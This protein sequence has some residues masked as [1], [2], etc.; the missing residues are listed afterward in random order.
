MSS[1]PPLSNAVGTVKF[2]CHNSLPGSFVL[3][4]PS[5]SFAVPIT[6]AWVI[7][8]SHG[9]PIFTVKFPTELMLVFADTFMLTFSPVEYW[10]FHPQSSGHMSNATTSNPENPV[11]HAP[12]IEGEHTE[13]STSTNPFGHL[14]KTSPCLL[15][16]FCG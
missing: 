3:F 2:T 14:V 8:P 10:A 7:S 11:S 16:K 1:C 13:G 5:S 15:V 9:L 6:W 12:P 4:H